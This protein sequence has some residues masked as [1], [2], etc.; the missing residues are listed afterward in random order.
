MNYEFIFNEYCKQ[1]YDK[2]IMN[3]LKELCKE[4]EFKCTCQHI[5]VTKSYYIVKVEWDYIN[6]CQCI[7]I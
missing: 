7:V 3:R 4:P 2:S 1:P 5:Y 6:D